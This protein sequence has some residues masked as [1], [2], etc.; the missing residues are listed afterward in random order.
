MNNQEKKTLVW[1][2]VGSFVLLAV[3]I[4]VLAVMYKQAQKD[5]EAKKAALS[6]T[7]VQT[8]YATEYT[9]E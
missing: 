6:S 2:Y 3:T 1:R 5:D 8:E 9:T 7:Q 4:L